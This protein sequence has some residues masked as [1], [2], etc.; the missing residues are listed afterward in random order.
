[1][2]RIEEAMEKAAQLRHGTVTPV[3]TSV[4]GPNLRPVHVPPKPESVHKS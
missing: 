3:A 1:M 2:S 4:K